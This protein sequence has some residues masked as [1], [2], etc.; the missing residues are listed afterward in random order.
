MTN[1]L[2]SLNEENIKNNPIENGDILMTEIKA[3]T[4]SRGDR[5]VEKSKQSI[6]GDY[7][8]A[9]IEVLEGLRTSTSTTRY[10]Y[11]WYRSESVT[12]SLCGSN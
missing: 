3:K 5:L 8:A 1:D 2:F 9:D 7:T 11:R 4:A 12:P 6:E 10:V